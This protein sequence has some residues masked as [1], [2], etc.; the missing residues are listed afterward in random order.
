MSERLTISFMGAVRFDW[1][2]IFLKHSTTSALAISP[3]AWP[4]IPSDTAQSPAESDVNTASWLTVL[5]RPQ[6]VRLTER[7]R[8][9]DSMDGP[10]H[11]GTLRIIPCPARFDMHN[12]SAT[13]RR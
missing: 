11:T 4:P 2:A 7:Y 3:D 10:Y 5:T 12:Y 1:M 6:S 8:N 9:W 13:F